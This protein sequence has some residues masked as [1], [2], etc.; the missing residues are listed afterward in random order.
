MPV[1]FPQLNSAGLITQR[2]YRH[3]SGFLTDIKELECGIRSTWGWRGTGLIGF[4]TRGL[5]K[6][7]V[8]FQSITD[9]E[10]AVLRAFFDSMRGRYGEFT[11]LDPHGN[12]VDSPEDF[13][14]AAWNRV[15]TVVSPGYPDAFGGSRGT[16][17]AGGSVDTAVLPGGGASG[18]VLC[19]SVYAKAAGTAT[20]GFQGISTRTWQLNPN[21]WMRISHSV[22]L[23]TNAAVRMQLSLSGSSSVFGAQCVPGP[24]EGGYLRKPG[25][26]P[27]CRFATDS[28]SPKYLGPNQISLTLPIEEYN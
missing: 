26:Y 23:A 7:D 16:V 20:I 24:G 28:F 4:P 15:G 3:T 6:F 21:G 1:Y 14:A 11:F 9:A 12:M 5:G 18:F 8:A 22:T 13:S 2:P 10:L 25:R 19:A 17:L 27:K